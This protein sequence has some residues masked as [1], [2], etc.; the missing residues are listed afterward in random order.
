MHLVITTLGIVVSVL[1][2]CLSSPAERS[3]FS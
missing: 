1:N 3:A 2:V